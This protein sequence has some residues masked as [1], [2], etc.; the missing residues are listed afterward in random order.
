VFGDDILYRADSYEV[1]LAGLPL[2]WFMLRHVGVGRPAAERLRIAAGLLGS[3]GSAV[4]QGLRSHCLTT[5]QM[6]DRLR[7]GA[8]V[9]GPLQPVFTR[10]AG[11]GLPRGVRG[12]DIARPTPL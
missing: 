12:D 9:R 2:L 8:H 10:W 5:A 1:D 11:K 6:A 3:G 7:L 4:E